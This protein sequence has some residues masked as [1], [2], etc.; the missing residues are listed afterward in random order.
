L[1]LQRHGLESVQ[2]EVRWLNELISAERSRS[3]APGRAPDVHPEQPDR[4]PAHPS[5]SHNPSTT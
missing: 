4:P 5:T 2:R 1:A 3:A